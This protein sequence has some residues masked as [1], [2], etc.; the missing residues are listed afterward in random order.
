[1][2]VLHGVGRDGSETGRRRVGKIKICVIGVIS[3]PVQA[4]SRH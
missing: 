1:M 3:V 2:E 4:S